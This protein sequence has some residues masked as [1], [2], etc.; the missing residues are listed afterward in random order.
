M[1]SVRLEDDTIENHV[2]VTPWTSYASWHVE[3]QGAQFLRA[4]LL[5]AL[6]WT[7]V[8]KAEDIE[9]PIA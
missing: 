3:A 7:S 9:A 2:V 5:M 8:S 4:D 6:L 1:I